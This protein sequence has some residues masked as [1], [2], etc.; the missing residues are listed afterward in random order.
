[1]KDWRKMLG[2]IREILRRMRMNFDPNYVEGYYP[3]PMAGTTVPRPTTTPRPTPTVTPTP[4][5]NMI[6]RNP[7]ID[8][9]HPQP[10]VENAMQTAGQRY[11]GVNPQLLT[12]LLYDIALSESG[13][14]PNAQNSQSTA[15]GLYQFTDPT[16]QTAQVYQNKPGSTLSL[17]NLDKF[18]PQTA[19]M[20]AAYLISKGQLGR[21]AASQPAWGGGYTPE[22]LAP[23]FVQSGGG[24]YAN[25]QGR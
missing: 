1:M 18:D 20:L 14:N 24:N 16:M 8:Q 2:N 7:N 6:A 11:G 12:S 25:A 3:G 5:P 23:F 13:F 17:D 10:Q 19:A 21:W 9:Y 4:R 22:E 15:G